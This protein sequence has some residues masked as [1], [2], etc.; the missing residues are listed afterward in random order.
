MTQELARKR[1][2]LLELVGAGTQAQVL[3]SIAR[4][5]KCQASEAEAIAAPIW[6]INDWCCCPPDMG[7][8]Y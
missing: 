8:N 1:R 4:G 2:L 7:K 6:K 5:A 3:P